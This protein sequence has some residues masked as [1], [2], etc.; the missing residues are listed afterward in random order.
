MFEILI[1]IHTG[2]THVPIQ[3]CGVKIRAAEKAGLITRD[4]VQAVPSI[5]AEGLAYLWERA[6]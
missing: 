1:A 3:R 4:G 5:T 6:S 2:G